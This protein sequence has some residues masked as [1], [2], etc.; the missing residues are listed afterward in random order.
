[1]VC[2]PC[3]SAVGMCWFRVLGDPIFPGDGAWVLGSGY[4]L[5]DAVLEPQS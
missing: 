5:R 3:P 4:Q 2:V 1:M